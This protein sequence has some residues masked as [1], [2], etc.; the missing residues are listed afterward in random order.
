MLSSDLM[1]PPDRTVSNLKEDSEDPVR[2]RSRDPSADSLTLYR[3]DCPAHQRTQSGSDPGPS[4]CQSHALPTRLPCSP[5]DSVRIR[6]R[7]PRTTA[8]PT[9]GPSQDPISG[10]S[11]CQSHALTTRLPRPPEDPVRIRSRDPRT[12]SLT[13]YRLDCPAH[14]RTQSGSDPG[15]HVLSVSRSTD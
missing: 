4:Y 3:L 11:Y 2:I 5:K 10:S 1:M 9:R 8:P 14:Q 6:S 12:V 7:D 13:L 15:T